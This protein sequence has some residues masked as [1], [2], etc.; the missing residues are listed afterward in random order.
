V[1]SAIVAGASGYTGALAA[2]L[3][4]RHPHFDLVAVTSR[5][6]A[7][8]RLDDLYPYHRVP[9][10]LE[11]LDLDRHGR[12][13]AAIVAY[14]HGAAAPLVAGLRE[15][16]VK[17]VDLSADFRI[18]DVPE[19]ERWYVEHPHPELVDGAVYGLP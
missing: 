9:L 18:R 3:L 2:K 12:V 10:E 13:D 4:Q 17:V 8:R 14:P 6:D 5:S 11:E 19:Y 15:R 16:G 1:P 7:G